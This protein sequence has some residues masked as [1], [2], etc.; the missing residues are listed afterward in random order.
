VDGIKLAVTQIATITTAWR[1]QVF[2]A[3]PPLMDGSKV[4]RSATAVEKAPGH[5]G[6]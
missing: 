4:R 3:N 1:F 6:D 5:E 2:R